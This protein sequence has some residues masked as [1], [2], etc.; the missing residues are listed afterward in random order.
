MRIYASNSIALPV[1]FQERLIPAMNECSQ[2]VKNTV[3]LIKGLRALEVPIVVPRQYPK[4]L[5]D[6]V[7]EIKDALGGYTPGDKLT[8]SACQEPALMDEIEAS[9]RKI[10]IVCGIE[11][12][13]CVIQSVIDLIAAGYT[14][15]LVADCVSSR[16]A[17]SKHYAIERAK[18]EGAIITT[19]E[20]I[21]FE[22]TAQVGTD[23]FKIISKLVK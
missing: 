17:E 20:A 3:M 23:A 12:H 9:G 1:D 11:A 19:A 10:V 8:F 2:L 7:P 13:V 5:G 22:M 6:L 4:G 14:A 21:L 18:C 15:V 16:T